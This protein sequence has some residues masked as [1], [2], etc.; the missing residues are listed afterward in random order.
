[1]VRFSIVKQIFLVCLLSL[2]GWLSA[3][4]AIQPTHIDFGSVNETET[5][6]LMVTIFNHLP[7]DLKINSVHG[8][9]YYETEAFSVWPSSFMVPA[10]GSTQVSV[11]FNPDQNMK[12][13][14]IIVFKTESRGAI[15]LGVEGQGEFS[16]SYYST[17]KNKSEQVLKNTLKSLLAQ[18][19]SDKGYNGARDKM[20][21]SIDNVNG[22]VECVY[23]GRTATFNTRSG[24]N[25]NNFNCE[26]TWPQSLFSSATPMKSDMHH[27]YP[28]DVTAN[29]Q[30]GN[31]PFGVVTGSPSWQ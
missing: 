20:Y 26:H 21:G 31:L 24:A 17:T 10:F 16:N 3:Q 5:D 27:L 1:M 7:F 14:Q 22:D 11:R 13:E 25:A 18:N 2:S 28:T 12:Y 6:T 23:T 8:F 29:S 30:R 4:F 9:E 19:Y 15:T